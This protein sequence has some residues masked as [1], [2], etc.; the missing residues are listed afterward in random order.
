[1]VMMAVPIHK[2]FN[3]H[4]Q[5]RLSSSDLNYKMTPKNTCPLCGTEIKAP[6]NFIFPEIK[7]KE[8]D[9]ATHS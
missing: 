5:Y 8:S 3:A 2:L 7:P 6:Y 1:M 4:Y 9:H